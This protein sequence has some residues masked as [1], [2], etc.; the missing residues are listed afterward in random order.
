MQMCS[1]KRNKQEERCMFGLGG[2]NTETDV[3]NAGWHNKEK[4]QVIYGMNDGMT[5]TSFSDI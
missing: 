4:R 1:N 3:S 5:V 2:G